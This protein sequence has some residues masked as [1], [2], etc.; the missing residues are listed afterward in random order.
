M[1]LTE[2]FQKYSVVTSART[3]SLLRTINNTVPLRKSLAGQEVNHGAFLPQ[4]RALFHLKT[5]PEN[6]E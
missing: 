3:W 1:W 4:T 2:F 6:R 5:D